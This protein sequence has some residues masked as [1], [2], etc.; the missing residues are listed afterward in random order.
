MGGAAVPG[1]Y[2]RWEWRLVGLNFLSLFFC[3]FLLS[4]LVFV[5]ILNIVFF[6]I[7]IIIIILI[8]FLFGICVLGMYCIVFCIA[9]LHD[10]Y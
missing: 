9:L 4:L 10:D 5:L 2:G 8:V 6:F 3:L 1:G 7:F